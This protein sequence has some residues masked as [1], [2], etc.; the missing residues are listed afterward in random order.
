MAR[1]RSGYWV[2]GTMLLLSVLLG[3]FLFMG[4]QYEFVRAAEEAAEAAAAAAKAAGGTAAGWVAGRAGTLRGG[5]GRDSIGEQLRW[6]TH[7][8]SAGIVV[9]PRLKRENPVVV[10]VVPMERLARPF[11]R[12]QQWSDQSLCDSDQR[13]LYGGFM[14]GDCVTSCVAPAFHPLLPCLPVLPV[15]HALV[16]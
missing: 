9:W 1:P 6:I 4:A 10:G 11:G 3:A 8:G 14:S 13:A 7:M 5:V 16:S 2:V 15:L 12:L